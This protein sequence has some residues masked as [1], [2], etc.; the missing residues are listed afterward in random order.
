V[1]LKARE[2]EVRELS[3]RGCGPETV[4][5]RVHCSAGTYVRSLAE[6]IAERLGTVGHL[7][8]LVRL[9]IGAWSLDDAKPLEWIRSASPESIARELRPLPPQTP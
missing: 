7:E 5:F 2:I 6:S 4:T 9:R 1:S 8:R 3:L